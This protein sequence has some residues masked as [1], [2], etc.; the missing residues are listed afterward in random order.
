M[1]PAITEHTA[2]SPALVAEE[3]RS[4]SISG[5]KALGGRTLV[6]FALS[7]L[8]L[9]VL[10]NFLDKK[11]YGVFGFAAWIVTL[12][13]FVGDGGLASGLVRQHRV[14][15]ANETFTIFVCQQVMTAI[16]VAFLWIAS[17]FIIR[18]YQMPASTTSLLL[19]MSGSLMFY[20]LR[21]V[22]MMTLERELR[23]GDIARCELIEQVISTVLKI[24]LAVLK[25]GV[26]SL[27]ASHV[28]GLFVGLVCV[29]AISP[30]RPQGR[31][32]K[33]VLPPLVKFALPFQLNAIFPAIAGGWAPIIIGSVL[34][35]ESLG[36]V[37]WAINVASSPSRL[38][39]VLIRVAFPAFSRLQE[40][41]KA[42]D[43]YLKASLRIMNAAFGTVIPLFVLS[44]PVLVHFVLNPK[45]VPAIPLVQWFSLEVV[46]FTINGTVCAVQN[47]TGKAMERF[48]VTLG[49]AAIRWSLGYIVV[50][51][52]G[53]AGLGLAVAIFTAIEL[54]AAAYLVRRHNPQCRTLIA[55]SFAPTLFSALLVFAALMVGQG[56]FPHSLYLQTATSLAVF[57]G[58]TVLRE[59]LT[60]FQF[61][62]PEL[63]RVLS[64]LRR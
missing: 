52:F 30:W 39:N 20:S 36:L 23:F 7:L 14:P 59:W 37:N 45:W 27:V 9:I 6:S 43:R 32:D 10:S 25:F 28:L 63:P 21:I 56:I 12:G 60:P 41:P 8:S 26:W 11:D 53:L 61:I 38:N 3:V 44:L 47:A 57:L 58:L 4:R 16:V 49:M 46:L 40:D 54:F 35:V 62:R 55:D 15:T 48:F 51:F 29:W 24:L 34:G 13:L 17:P 42:L 64:L 18:V 2:D 22:P 5:I 1:T 33:S 50:R 31:F 19:L